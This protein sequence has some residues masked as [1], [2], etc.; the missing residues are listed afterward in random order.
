MALA[1]RRLAP[2][3]WL[4]QWL[5]DLVSP[6]GDLEVLWAT[7]LIRITTHLVSTKCG[8]R[9]VRFPVPRKTCHQ[10]GI[11]GKNR[12]HWIIVAYFIFTKVTPSC[13]ISASLPCSK[14]PFFVWEVYRKGPWMRCI[15]SLVALGT[16]LF[17]HVLGTLLFYCWVHLFSALFIHFHLF[18]NPLLNRIRQNPAEIQR[19][20]A[21]IS[22][23]LVFLQLRVAHGKYHRLS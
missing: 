16:G 13:S 22:I 7:A 11:V 12:N 3:K 1:W 9:S 4:S 14:G 21:E 23:C 18:S 6:A 17:W 10:M 19:H 15:L 20:R 8:G 2:G 5:S